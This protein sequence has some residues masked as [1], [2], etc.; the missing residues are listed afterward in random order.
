MAAA[1]DA[2]GSTKIS[3]GTLIILGYGRVSGE[4]KRKNSYSLS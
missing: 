2:D 4:W 1:L 3:G